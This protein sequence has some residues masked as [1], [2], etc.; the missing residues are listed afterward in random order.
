[1]AAP[2]DTNAFEDTPG[3][4]TLL[5]P[6]TLDEC[7]GAFQRSVASG[8]RTSLSQLNIASLSV[9]DG[10]LQPIMD[11]DSDEHEHEHAPLVESPGARGAKRGKSR[12]RLEMLLRKFAQRR[13]TKHPK[14]S[15]THAHAAAPDLAEDPFDDSHGMDIDGEDA[16]APF[17]VGSDAE[18]IEEDGAG[19]DGAVGA[20]WPAVPKTP[21]R[22][23]RTS[24][25]TTP[26]RSPRSAKSARSVMSWQ[27]GASSPRTPKSTRSRVSD[28]S[29]GSGGS[30]SGGSSYRRRLLRRR[31][32]DTMA[33]QLKSVQ[34]LGDEAV[35]A[36]ARATNVKESRL[37]YRQLDRQLRDRRRTA[38]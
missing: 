1:M 19:V 17:R 18:S 8:R 30:S 7:P 37:R 3:L 28:G 24:P 25:P 32:R 21:R 5:P 29:P 27:T 4:P 10:E 38:F 11:E 2:M 35:P 22:A 6:F 14:A 15:P 23:K 31:T 34:L 36:V 16:V 12:M 13:R 33:S 26:G 9:R 20:D